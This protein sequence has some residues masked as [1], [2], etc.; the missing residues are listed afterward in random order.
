M[1]DRSDTTTMAQFEKEAHSFVIRIWKENHN[2][3]AD[4][5]SQM[6]I[7]RGWIRHVQ[8]ERQHYFADVADIGPIVARYLNPNAGNDRFEPIQGKNLP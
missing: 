7:W 8:S 4:E 6:G 3:Y 5:P 2:S 1:D